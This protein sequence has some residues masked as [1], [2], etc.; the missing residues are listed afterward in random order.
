[1]FE[2]SLYIVDFTNVNCASSFVCLPVELHNIA[3][4]TYQV[5]KC[6][7]V[8]SGPSLKSIKTHILPFPLHLAGFIFLS[9]MTVW[10]LKTRGRFWPQIQHMQIQIQFNTHTKTCNIFF[11]KLGASI[12]VYSG[13]HCVSPS[14]WIYYASCQI[15]SNVSS[16]TLK[17]T[18]PWNSDRIK[19]NPSLFSIIPHGDRAKGNFNT[20][21]LCACYDS[22]LSCVDEDGLCSGTCVNEDECVVSAM[23]ILYSIKPEYA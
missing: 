12:V 14:S 17:Q 3:C 7:T 9:Q 10:N 5:I 18:I 15:S 4:K 2:Q 8:G 21:K 1:M 16:L 22:F 13:S 19:A 20:K 23:Q 6:F 11:T